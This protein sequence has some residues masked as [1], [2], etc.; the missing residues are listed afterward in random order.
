VAQPIEVP[1]EALPDAVRLALLDRIENDALDLPVLPEAAAEVVAATGRP[2][3]DVRAVA[4]VIR[5]DQAM[6]AHLLRIANSPLY[7]P[8]VKI[9]SL[10]QALTRLGT[11]AVREIALMIAV[12]TRAFQ[13]KGFEPQIKSLFRHC[14]ATAL[15][16][17]EI[18]RTCRLSV[19]EAFLA[20]LL[21]DVGR[22]VL[23]QAL[24]D[25][26][27]EQR[28]VPN[29]PALLAVA[30]EH[31]ARVGSKLVARWSLADRLATTILHHH[32]AEGVADTQTTT[33]VVSLADAVA[34]ATVDQEVGAAR[35]LS[36]HH[37]LRVLNLYPEDVD[38]LLAMHTRI[39]E[40]VASIA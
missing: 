13:A 23:L 25:I 2:D 7:L 39:S 33:L 4:E 40:T 10:Q 6:A 21:H 22:P 3:C 20:G 37:A 16:A 18:A 34:H 8:R 27:R 1:P 11:R 14:L 35:A 28:I 32:D 36:S 29:K 31:H 15:Y 5:R 30:A 24:A 38:K 26:C 19:E 9:V 17:Q 12:K